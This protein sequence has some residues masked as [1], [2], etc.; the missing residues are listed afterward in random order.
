[1]AGKSSDLHGNAPDDASVIRDYNLIIPADCVAS[2]DADENNRV[3]E[4]MARVF[5]A[6]TRPSDELDLEKLPAQKQAQ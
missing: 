1:M 6:D 4:L 2:E 3:L 5:E